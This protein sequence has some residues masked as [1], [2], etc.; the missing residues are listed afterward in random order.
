MDAS[1]KQT[2]KLAKASIDKDVDEMFQGGKSGEGG[3]GR[4]KGGRGRKPSFPTSGQ[5][6]SSEAGRQGTIDE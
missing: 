1:S 5:G 3:Q 2:V 6:M 4:S